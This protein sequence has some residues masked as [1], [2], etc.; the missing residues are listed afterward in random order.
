MTQAYCYWIAGV[1]AAGTAKKV[2]GDPYLFI[3][4]TMFFVY[5]GVSLWSAC[6]SDDS[7]ARELKQD[8]VDR[9]QNGKD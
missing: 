4:M 2:E 1:H 3:F 9:E 7:G 8:S 5:V 6:F